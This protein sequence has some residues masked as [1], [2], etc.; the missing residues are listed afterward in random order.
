[1]IRVGLV[2]YGLAGATFHAPLIRAC[3]RMQLSGVMT[4]RDVPDA[5]PDLGGLFDR[6]DLIVIASPNATHF[7][8][9][10]AALEAGK[11]VVV[12][13]PF[14]VTVA[15][16]DGL[17]GLAESRGLKLTVFHNRRWDG[18]FLTVRRVL[19]ELGK[20]MLYHAHWDR[21]RPGLRN[22]WKEV[23]NGATGVLI[24][25]GPH[26]IDQAL[27]LF[28][29]PD[30][31]TADIGTQRSGGSIDD[32]FELT[33]H[34]GAMRAVLGCSTLVADS[35]PRFAIHGVDGSFVKH[36]LDTQEAALKNDAEPLSRDFGTDTND[37]LLTTATGNHRT[38]ETERGRYIGFYE[39][40][41]DA[42]IDNLPLPVAAEEARNV[43]E[44][45]ALARISAREGRRITLAPLPS[46]A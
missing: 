10:K 3:S 38:V 31:L 8:I 14:T 9:A 35:R 34:Y 43:M 17:I 37:G 24:D 2:G 16:A 11:H 41:A 29:M 32:Y 27:Q 19:P 39:A 44:I 13:K 18:D 36:G 42:L 23:A 7:E 21:F 28:G 6:A 40:V 25:L 26:L 20:I 33:L 15:E 46:L 30:A 12:D 4:S 1:M 22:G 5:V 45:I